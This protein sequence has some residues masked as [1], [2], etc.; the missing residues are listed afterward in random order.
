M[1]K[2]VKQTDLDA[3][4][5]SRRNVYLQLCAVDCCGERGCGNL[6]ILVLDTNMFDAT[7]GSAAVAEKQIIIQ[8]R[9]KNFGPIEAR[10][11]GKPGA[12]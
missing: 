5:L 8:W 1:L 11:P 9:R 10:R 12:R 6:A 2:A 3:R 4:R 7:I